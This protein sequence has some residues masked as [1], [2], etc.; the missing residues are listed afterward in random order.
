MV[1]MRYSNMTDY[2][3]CCWSY[4][5]WSHYSTN[6]DIRIFHRLITYVCSMMNFSQVISA[7]TL[8]TGRR[9]WL[10]YFT[11]VT[12]TLRY[13]KCVWRLNSQIVNVLRTK[14]RRWMFWNSRDSIPFINGISARTQFRVYLFH[15]L[16]YTCIK[17]IVLWYKNL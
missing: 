14:T 7:E 11:I 12:H 4:G 17:K 5:G 15:Y 9:E 16:Y 8:A 6:F 1:F 13:E 2:W 10:F 3:E